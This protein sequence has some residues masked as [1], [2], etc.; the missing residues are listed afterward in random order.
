MTAE[1][2]RV[3]LGF[4]A[5]VLGFAGLL[6][7]GAVGVGLLVQRAVLLERLDRNITESLEQEAEEVRRLATRGFN[8]RTAEPFAGDVTAIFDTFVDRNVPGPSEAYMTFVDGELYQRTEGARVIETSHPELV[9]RW[10]GR[11]AGARGE[12]D[13]VAGPV[14]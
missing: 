10:A 5:R 4:R 2:R 11:T 3:R 13:T 8:P 1:R 12:V 14:R 7:I 9:A 6:L